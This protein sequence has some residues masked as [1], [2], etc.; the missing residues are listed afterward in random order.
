MLRRQFENVKLASRKGAGGV[1][2]KLKVILKDMR[3]EVFKVGFSK[4]VDME[5]EKRRR[6]RIRP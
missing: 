3:T 2:I 6:S 1:Y 5:K 4:E